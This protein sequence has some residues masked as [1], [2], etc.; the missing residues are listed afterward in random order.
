MP[1]VAWKIV[2]GCGPYAY[3]QR[4]RREG[5]T[6]ISDHI[7]YLGKLGA[8][9]RF[10]QGEL[11][12][13]RSISVAGAEPVT[14]PLL[15]PNYQELLKPHH[16]R[17]AFRVVAGNSVAGYVYNGRE[18]TVESDPPKREETLRDRGLDFDNVQ[19]FEWET[20]DY[21]NRIHIDPAGM[22]PP[23]LRHRAIGYFNGRL[24]NIVYT[25]RG[26]NLRMISMRVA[27]RD[28]REFYNERR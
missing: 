27:S 14:V 19:R 26:E 22:R 23:E 17:A 9:S 10:G 21:T 24:H 11:F 28:E 6:V 5:N 20:A 13:G 3:L 2:Y 4:S 18:L 1:K 7:K 8:Q 12:P 25:E 15:K 16:A